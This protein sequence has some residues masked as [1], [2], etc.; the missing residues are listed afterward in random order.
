MNF[1]HRNGWSYISGG[2]GVSTLPIEPENRLTFPETPRRRTINY[3]AGARWFVTD[4]VA[5]SFD[6]RF[7]A[8]SGVESTTPNTPGIP[9]TTLF[10]FAAGI[11]IH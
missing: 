9:H 3:G 6:L 8:L 2:L 4:H 5:F 7:H 10:V 1:G 11:S